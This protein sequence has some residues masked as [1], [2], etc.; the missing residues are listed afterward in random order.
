M[1]NWRLEP[2]L[3]IHLSGIV[4]FPAL[5]QV[6]LI[7]L[8]IGD[9]FGYIW[10]LSLLVIFAILPIL[11]MQLTRPFDIFS[12]LL[13]SLKAESLTNEQLK[14]LSLF[15]TVKHKFVSLLVAG[16]MTGILWLLYSLS[17]LSVGVVDWLPQ[18]R[19]LGM[20]IALIAFLGSNLFLQIPISV[21]LVLLTKKLSYVQTQP[22][23]I[24]EIEHNFTVPGIKV[25]K[26]LWFLPPKAE[27]NKLD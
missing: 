8:G 10:E 13:F 4:I 20:A 1:S 2:F 24:E 25:D 14:I 12:V 19:I 3:W 17:P 7:G 16:I 18:W 15:K 27:I 9:S 6:V 22:Y 26:I 21:L 11:W 23:P 5:L